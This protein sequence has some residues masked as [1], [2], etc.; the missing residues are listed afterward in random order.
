MESE[1]QRRSELCESVSHFP[2]T[3]TEDL[4]V[5]QETAKPNKVMK[6]SAGVQE[7][8]SLDISSLFE[9][10]L[11]FCLCIEART[12]FVGIFPMAMDCGV[13][14]SCVQLLKKADKGCLL[15][16]SSRIFRGL[17]IYSKATDI[18][19]TDT[20]A[21]VIDAVRPGLLDGSPCMYGSIAVYHVVIA[22]V[23]E[24]APQMPLAYL[25]HGEV[26]ALRGCSAVDDE[27]GN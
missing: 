6:R 23:T 1:V 8:R 13:R 16:R 19:D 4:V 18:T 3:D 9:E 21:V 7:C 10:F 27:F 5:L 25:L 22:D 2:R 11:I 26:L 14:E 17:A 12:G 15:R 20:V 24:A